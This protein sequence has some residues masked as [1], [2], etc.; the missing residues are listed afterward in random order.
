MRS[1]QAAAAGE[2]RGMSVVAWLRRE[3]E[4]YTSEQVRVFVCARKS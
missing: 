2:P 4:D 1:Q 3:H